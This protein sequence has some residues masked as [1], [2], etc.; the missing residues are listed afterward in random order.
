MHVK[1]MIHVFADCEKNE[2]N[3]KEEETPQCVMVQGA[4]LKGMQGKRKRTE[5]K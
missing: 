1:N 5:N 4:Y 3:F 2:T